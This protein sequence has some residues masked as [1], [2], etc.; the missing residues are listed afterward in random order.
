M[1]ALPLAVLRFILGVTFCVWATAYLTNDRWHI[2]FVQ[3]SLLFK[4]AGFQ[5]VSL[6]PGDGMWWHFQITRIAA[7][8]FALG[9]L[10]R[11]N[12]FVMAASM[13]YV[14]LVDRQIYNNHDYLL[15]CTAMLCGFLPCG[16]RL[17]LDRLIF[18][19]NSDHTSMRLWH[20]WL[21]RFQLGMPYVFGGIAKLDSDWLA[22]QPAGL[23][24]ASR[25][26]TPVI[27]RLFALPHAGLAMAWG[28]LLFD[29]LVVPALIWKPTRWF[30]VAA[31]LMF[32][33]TNATIFQIGVFPW[34]MLAT[35]YV[36]F[37]VSFLPDLVRHVAKRFRTGEANADSERGEPGFAGNASSAPDGGDIRVPRSVTGIS[38]LERF[39][40]SIAIV[41]V[42][43]QLVLPLRPWVLPG[44]PSW[45]ERG[46][47]FAWRMMLRH[48]DCLLW[49]RIQTADDFLIVPAKIVMT[50]NQVTRAPRDPE[51][52]R[53]AAV[54]LQSFAAS[55]GQVGA[56]VYALHLVSLNG[57][58]ARLLV[59]P[60]VDLT[61]VR[62]HWFVDDWVNQDPGPLPAVPWRVPFD[63][64]WEQIELPNTFA[65]LRTMRPSQAEAMFD[66]L[67]RQQRESVRGNSPQ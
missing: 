12:A 63:L 53:Q 65:E 21:V 22:G 4:Y 24:V 15:G 44:N 55:T 6:W 47:R 60:T 35:L 36:F 16:R 26:D 58:P 52:V 51:L 61:K 8:L 14:L 49:F 29:L 64:W 57:R 30:A 20:W 33:L 9:F 32:H 18:H 40:I 2:V 56:E 17:S 62:R 11:I 48:K 7:I 66:E 38:R 50:P 43:V 39:G 1:D 37:P 19:R 10:T 31:A 25:L 41:Y 3:P 59:D 42:I 5:W 28:G 34:F 54:K 13:A 23:F 46:H 45:N 67:A 27:G